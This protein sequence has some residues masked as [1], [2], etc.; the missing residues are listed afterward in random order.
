MRKKI[1]ILH[2]PLNI[3]SLKKE[4]LFYFSSSETTLS[5]LFFSFYN[6]NLIAMS[7]GTLFAT[8]QIRSL[9]PKAL[10][11]HFNLDVK[12]S[13]K[14]AVYEKNFPLNKI[15]AFVGPKGFKL[16]E[17]IAIS[18]YCMYLFLF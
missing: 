18:L 11:K 7:Q 10:I 2:F 3:T 13:D 5:F 15:P 14:D 12:V 17:V 9:A 1:F 16:T 4:K 8:Q 6:N